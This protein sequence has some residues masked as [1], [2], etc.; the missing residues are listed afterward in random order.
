MPAVAVR[1]LARHTN[2]SETATRVSDRSF[3][4]SNREA[5]ELSPC[6]EPGDGG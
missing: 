1:A 2:I 4:S 3:G 5:A 6:N